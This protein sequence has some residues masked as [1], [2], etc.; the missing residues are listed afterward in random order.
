[1]KSSMKAFGATLHQACASV[2]EVLGVLAVSEQA[3]TI[4][5]ALAAS[6]ASINSATPTTPA[7]PGERSLVLREALKVF[8]HPPLSASMR[9]FSTALVAA[10][11]L[12]HSPAMAQTY[13]ANGR[14][15]NNTIARVFGGLGG[16][17][18]GN[19]VA[20]DAN[21]V[22]KTGLTLGGA[23][24]GQSVGDMATRTPTDQNGRPIV[25]TGIDAQGRPVYTPLSDMQQGS[26]LP[27]PGSRIPAQI[28][29][30]TYDEAIRVA[31]GYQVAPA[32]LGSDGQE[33]R[34]M[35]VQVHTALYSM[36][37]ETV[38]LRAIARLALNDLNSADL[39]RAVAPGD[40]RRVAE[41]A[42]VNQA[43][44]QAFRAYAQSYQ[45]VSQAL[46]TAE[47]NNFNVT[48]QRV[49]MATVPGDLKSNAGI[50]AHWPRVDDT[51][52]AKSAEISAVAAGNAVPYGDVVTVGKARSG[53]EQYDRSDA[54]RPRQR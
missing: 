31:S 4:S 54:N 17:V 35:D 12:T 23:Y 14:S 1:M 2:G 49:L 26:A 25:Q 11:A 19:L 18:L 10:A 22:W 5:L 39:A 33:W 20:K 48:A 28:S 8:S 43:Y 34:A 47:R 3:K 53:D 30:A 7:T 42:A 29:Q 52:R 45:Q 41:F 32:T 37:V 16:A 46:G 21:N 15:E 50:Q 6:Q 27:R 51:I 44:S 36:M 24:L 40:P 13:D 38:A 9:V